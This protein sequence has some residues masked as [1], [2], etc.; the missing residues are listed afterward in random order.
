MHA[1]LQSVI[2]AIDEA[3][4]S[5]L[6]IEW[7]LILDRVDH[8]T[9]NYLHTHKPASANFV[10]VNLG[11][12]GLARN[13]GTPLSS[14]QFIS[15]IDAGDFWSPNW[16]TEAHSFARSQSSPKVIFHSHINLLL[17]RQ[18]SVMAALDSE[19][20]SFSKTMLFRK[21]CWT[22]S[23]FARR[24][25]YLDYPYASLEPEKG[26]AYADWHWNCETLAAG[27]AHKIV[28]DTFH[29]YSKPAPDQLP[30]EHV[31]EGPGVIRPSKLFALAYQHG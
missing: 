25:I 8:S 11:D 10:E 30:P 3:K 19:S 9:R 13:H 1:A 2:M 18:N 28:P 14:G 7:I 16:L 12:A 23:P 27:I 4:K 21:N 5:G 29:C 6:T 22:P 31:E 15:F 24:E 20:S 26:F 17:G